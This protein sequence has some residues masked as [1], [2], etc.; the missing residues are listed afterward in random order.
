[1][2]LAA[3]TI[4]V[5]CDGL[6]AVVRFND[7]PAITLATPHKAELAGHMVNAWLLEGENLLEVALARIPGATSEPMFDIHLQKIV[8]QD[9][10]ETLLYYQWTPGESPLPD[11][12]PAVVLRHRMNVARAFGRWQWQDARPFH[13]SDRPDIEAVVGA[14]HRAASLRDKRAM[15]ALLDLKLEEV[16]R[17]RGRPHDLMRE[18]QEVYFSSFVDE[19]DFALA[20]LDPGALSLTLHAGGRVV[21]VRGPEGASPIR[22]VGGGMPFEYDM[23]LSH[24]GGAFRIVR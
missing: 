5:M 21:E 12:G 24:V 6:S 4:Q 7:Y 23:L 1:M 20:P 14:F 15:V 3:N 22:G 17:S 11:E 8:K 13:P 10:E 2:T 9:E 19:P 16:G 18:R